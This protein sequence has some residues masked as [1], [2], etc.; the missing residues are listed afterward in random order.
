MFPHVTWIVVLAQET[1][2]K[3]DPSDTLSK[4]CEIGTHRREVTVRRNTSEN[5]N[6]RKVFSIQTQFPLMKSNMWGI[7]LRGIL[8]PSLREAEIFQGV[9]ETL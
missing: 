5:S 9:T 7:V 3:G 6:V 8:D 2:E 4:R 1:H